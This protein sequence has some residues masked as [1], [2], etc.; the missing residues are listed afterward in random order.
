[1]AEEV[2]D[3]IVQLVLQRSWIQEARLE[4]WTSLSAAVGVMIESIDREVAVGTWLEL[5]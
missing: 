2:D 5:C 1:M 3:A 4:V